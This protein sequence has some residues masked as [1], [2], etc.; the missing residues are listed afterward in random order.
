MTPN[1]NSVLD[2]PKGINL[3]AQILAHDIIFMQPDAYSSLQKYAPLFY[4]LSAIASHV[5]CQCLTTLKSKIL[6]WCVTIAIG[7]THR[8]QSLKM[9]ITDLHLNIFQETYGEYYIC[10]KQQCLIL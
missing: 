9:L 4:Q 3:G 10:I 5:I 2:R 6:T 8:Q 7:P 1:V